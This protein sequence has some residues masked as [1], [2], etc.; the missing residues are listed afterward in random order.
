[1]EDN[2]R[3]HYDSIIHFDRDSTG[4]I[5]ETFNRLA[6]TLVKDTTIRSYMIL[7]TIIESPV[8]ETVPDE[9][10]DE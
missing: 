6:E 9:A 10:I 7:N 8:I 2:V 1:M 5:T 4:R 3:T